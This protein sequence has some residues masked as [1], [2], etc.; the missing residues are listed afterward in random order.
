[1]PTVPL[2]NM[3]T[4]VSDLSDNDSHGVVP[5]PLSHDSFSFDSFGVA[6]FFGGDSSVA[7]MA[8]VNLIPGRKWVGW[9]N[10]PGSYEIAKKYGPLGNNKLFDGLFPDGEHDPAR[11]FK[12]DGGKGPQFVAA[13]SGT[14]FQQ[15]GH[16]AHLI[17]SKAVDMPFAHKRFEGTH[18]RLTA[19]PTVTVVNMRHVSEARLKKSQPLLPQ[20]W[21]P[22]WSLVPIV[23]S[24]AACMTCAL[25][26][27]WFCFASIAVGIAA[28]GLACLIIG[29][30]KLTFT[31][32]KPA[33]NAP[34]GDGVL[35]GER[36]WIVLIGAEGVVNA[37]TRGRFLLQYGAKK[38][39]KVREPLDQSRSKAGNRTRHHKEGS[40][41]DTVGLL[42]HID[43]GNHP[44]ASPSLSLSLPPTSTLPS[45]SSM[46]S[47][48]SM[49]S[50]QSTSSTPSSSLWRV[51][52]QWLIG[53]CAVLLMVQFIGQLLVIP[54]GTLFGQIM[55]IS[56]V[57]TSWIYNT[58]LSAI[59]RDELQ[60]QILMKELHLEEKD[61]MHKY[62]LNTFTATVA[63]TCFV[64]AAENPLK[65]PLVF[66]DAML[67][68]NTEVWKAWKGRM[69]EKLKAGVGTRVKFSEANLRAVAQSERELLKTLFDDAEDAWCAWSEVYSSVSPA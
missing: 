46:L 39:D 26:G 52:P 66:L 16:L 67:P 3:F 58:F 41:T 8:T 54:H 55:F 59:D 33:A 10:N 44:A 14:V 9:Y 22:V 60:I 30:G 23:V 42:S 57:F 65:D 13:H 24:V 18:G 2:A 25:V 29:S 17:T 34:P 19:G 15:T 5:L 11:L 68:N 31:H 40:D 53:A 50:P 62:E 64:L 21:T 7:A 56:T 51:L 45:T 20:S 1:M 43:H 69:A 38:S 6:G 63:F 47:T 32:P 36:A 12:L 37:F 48:S 49:P 4:E 35:K 27:D 28:H 61:H